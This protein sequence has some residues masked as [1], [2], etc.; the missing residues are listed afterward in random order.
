MYE[1]APVHVADEGF[2]KKVEDL[3]AAVSLHFAH[4]KF[5]AG[6]QGLRMTTAIAAKSL[7]D[8][9]RLRNWSSRLQNEVVSRFET[10]SY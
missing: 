9:G 8:C 6:A 3:K 7:I 10:V 5:C 2:S 1:H 4:Y